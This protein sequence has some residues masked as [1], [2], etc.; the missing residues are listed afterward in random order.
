M[1]SFGDKFEELDLSQEEIDRLTKCMKDEKFR[2]LFKEYAEEISNPD[3]RKRYEE[4]IAML[5]KERGVDVKFINPEPGHVLKTTIKGDNKKCFINICK[6][7]VLGKPKSQPSVQGSTK[8]MQWAIPHSV[9]QAREDIDR[10]KNKC[11][12]YDVVFHPDTYYMTT[13][14]TRFKQM[15]HDTAIDA[16]ERRFN[17]TL[18][19]DDIKFP[20][21]AFKGTPMASVIRT[22]ANDKSKT[23][24]SSSTTN[25]EWMYKPTPPGSD[26]EKRPATKENEKSKADK[27]IEKELG[28]K[29]ITPEYKIVERGYFDMQ[30]FSMIPGCTKSTRPKELLITV[31]LPKVTAANA[32]NLEIFERELKLKSSDPAHYSLD[33]KLPYP[34]D[35]SKGFAKFDKKEKKLIVTLEVLPPPPVP[36]IIPMMKD[37]R[38][39]AYVKSKV[40]GA[41]GVVAKKK[42]EK[43]LKPKFTEESR[44]HYQQGDNWQNFEDEDNDTTERKASERCTTPLVHTSDE[45]VK[46]IWKFDGKLIRTC[47]Q[48]IYFQDDLYVTIIIDVVQIYQNSIWYVLYDNTI[49]F[50]CLSESL[51]KDL[52]NSL[53]S[54]W[55][56]FEKDYYIDPSRS[57]VDVSASNAVFLLR[58][59]KKG[60]IWHKMQAG[61]DPNE[62]R[63]RTF[64]TNRNVS[65]L[66]YDTKDLGNSY[67]PVPYSVCKTSRSEKDFLVLDL[68]P[69]LGNKTAAN[70][71]ESSQKLTN[72][73]QP[74]ENGA[75]NQESK[76]DDKGNKEKNPKVSGSKKSKSSTAA[77]SGDISEKM[78]KLKLNGTGAISAVV[79]NSAV[80]S[81]DDLPE[82]DSN[83]HQPPPP[84][85]SLTFEKN[86][87]K[88]ETVTNHTSSSAVKLS[89]SNIVFQL[90]D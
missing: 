21:M 41:E 78:S 31:G 72:G 82:D 85:P 5:E 16:V 47:P 64:A 77:G 20:K 7:D 76:Q 8:G 71:K 74:K 48:H 15:I 52:V 80:D 67:T 36:E 69:N 68:E 70:G 63:E 17:I 40:I 79:D 88:K 73:K 49:Q 18:N 54:F 35:E 44:T 10:A 39:T 34:V 22:P 90:D 14:N 29:Q 61:L 51:E 53:I 2:E 55:A 19:K 1:S 12:V 33:V 24:N 58:K 87:S 57:R 45:L 32:V 75:K 83:N 50:V 84:S 28:I 3:N 30:D 27:K 38:L 13:K 86:N 56:V 66:Y 46:M 42:D 37:D 4:E 9:S 23:D 59:A 89:S 26:G 81:D 43:D 62:L 25:N 6:N 60:Q 11:V 65:E